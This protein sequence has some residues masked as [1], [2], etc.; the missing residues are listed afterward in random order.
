[1]RL[2]LLGMNYAPEM[3]GIG[4]YTAGLAEHLACCGHQ[5]TVAT[6]LPHYPRWQVDDAYRGRWRWQEHQN[7]VDVRRTAVYL[8]RRRSAAQR[9]LYDS[10]LAAGALLNSLALPRP[11]VIFCISPPIQLAVMALALAQRWRS[12]FVLQIKDLP[13]D[14]ALAVGMLRPGPAVRVGRALERLVYRHADR[15]TVISDG[16]RRALLRQG[17]APDRIWQIPDWVDD[18]QLQPL[19]AD[20]ALRAQAGARDGDLLVLHTGNMGEKQGLDSAI[21]AGAELDGSLPFRLTLVGDGM[22][23]ERLQRLTSQL[24]ARSVSFLPLQPSETFRR[25]LASAD[26]FLLNQRAE[27]VDSVAPGKLLTYLAAGRPVVA[28]VNPTSEAA[29][30]IHDSGGGVT[31]PPEDPAAL[32]AA[33]RTLASDPA[34][35][36]AM[37]EHGRHFVAEHYARSKVLATFEQLLTQVRR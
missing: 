6:A 34:H 15:I 8:P 20:P 19:P 28:A 10:S 35:R 36:R 7:G 11:D 1:M 12:P 16:L 17:V 37:G 22:D 26:A 30:L 25:L 27:V 21:R 14:L 18:E 31:V 29:R 32:A 13:L 23:R 2:L 33:L 4:P 3:T 9:V 5:V 24:G